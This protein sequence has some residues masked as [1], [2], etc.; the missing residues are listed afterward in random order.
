MITDSDNL[1]FARV[2]LPILNKERA[3]NDI[4]SL[5]DNFSFWDDYRH[6]KMIPLMTKQG[7]G[8]SQGASNY[9][10]G[11]FTWLSYAPE[12]VVHWFESH[13]FLWA[14]AKAR[15]MALI[16]QSG[17]SNYEHIDCDSTEINTRQH[18]FRIVLQGTTDTLYFNTSS[19]NVSAPNINSAFIMDG[20]WPHG[21]SNTGKDVKVTIAMGAPWRGN[22]QYD[23]IDILMDRRHYTMPP[24]LHK[25]WRK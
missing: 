4:L 16:T 8:S 15:V 10:P 21:M 25:Y 5:P 17:I 24:D 20:G 18:K 12:E 22:D 3:A 14:G 1:M 13:V 19:G 9:R 2:D 6:T 23:N 11:D 7:Q